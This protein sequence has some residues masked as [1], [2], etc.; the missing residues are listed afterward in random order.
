MFQPWESNLEQVA[1]GHMAEDLP[2]LKGESA[3]VPK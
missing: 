1:S 2:S 3:H